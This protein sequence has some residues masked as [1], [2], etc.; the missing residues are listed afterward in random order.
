MSALV[1][2]L[3]MGPVERE[4]FAKITAYTEQI[5][6]LFPDGEDTAVVLSALDTAVALVL[7]D[8]GLDAEV[9]AKSLRVSIRRVEAAAER[10]RKAGKL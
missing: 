9:F 10:A 5:V 7:H 6:K 1:N 4:A 3:L 2:P 8:L